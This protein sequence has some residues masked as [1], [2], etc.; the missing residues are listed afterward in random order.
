MKS[1]KSLEEYVSQAERM[2]AACSPATLKG[3]IQEL[4]D[5][6]PKEAKLEATD[7]QSPV[8]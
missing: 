8:S 3:L 2:N 5:E 6:L 7:S 1:L 4:K